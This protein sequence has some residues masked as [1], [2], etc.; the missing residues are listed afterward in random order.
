MIAT[1]T[2]HQKV[3]HAP[4]STSQF[5]GRQRKLNLIWTYYHA[6]SNGNATVVLVSERTRDWHT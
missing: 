1:Y 6:A 3:D 4:I 2:G 5:V